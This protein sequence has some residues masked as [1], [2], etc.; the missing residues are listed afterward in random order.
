M[1]LLNRLAQVGTD[2]SWSIDNVPVGFGSVRVRATCLREG[3]TLTGQSPLFTLAG[4]RLSGLLPFG[5]GPVSPIPSELV[6]NPDTVRIASIGG[7]S[8]LQVIARSL[9]SG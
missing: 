4:R 9:V 1:S 2:G 5:L 7:T 6:I 3:A 8:R